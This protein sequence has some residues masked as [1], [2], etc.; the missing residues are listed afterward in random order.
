MGA[1]AASSNLIDRL[2]KVRGR[3]EA[4]ADLGKLTWFR[5]GGPAEVLYAPADQDDLV[6]FMKE[7]P[8]DVPL[9]FIGL[10]ANM[11]VRDGGVPGV[12]IQLGKAFGQVSSA[13]LV[14]RVG[15]GAVNA[16]VAS[17]AKDASI[18][19]L[20]F[21]VGIPG[22]VGGALRMNAGAYGREIK[23]VFL[24]ATGINSA[25]EIVKLDADQ[26][27]FGYRHTEIGDDWIF[28]GAELKG[29][30]DTPSNIAARMKE[31]RSE[32]EESQPT[33]ART[34]GSTFANPEG[35][36]AWQL[37]DAAG[38]RGL[39]VGGAQMSEKHTNFMLNT[40][41]ASAADLENLGEQV[42]KRVFEEAGI[43]LV[44]EIRRVGVNTKDPRALQP[45]GKKAGK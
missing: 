34:G 6:A 14:M 17:A 4:L 43:H 25:G 40:G 8:A 21:L 16:A 24:S 23:D 36:K 20:E 37:I 44:W 22:T 41:G 18:G 12:V 9:T 28:I 13:G 19:G 45:A 3:Y 32:R 11:L 31:I 42:R 5:V 30:R 33:Q 7:R 27:G 38:C 10:G 39:K 1:K 15:G 35:Q 26:M 29:E 2:P